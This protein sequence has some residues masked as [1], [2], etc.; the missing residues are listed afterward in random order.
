MIDNPIFGVGVESYGNWYQRYRT[1]DSI[2]ITDDF[3]YYNDN[4]HNYFIQLGANIGLIAF[5]IYSLIY[6]LITLKVLVNMRHFLNNS[7]N[8]SLS[9]V[10]ILFLIPAFVSIDSP[11]ISV[12]FWVIG[13][14]LFGLCTKG[15]VDNIQVNRDK[16]RNL[17]FL[18]IKLFSIFLILSPLLYLTPLLINNVMFTNTLRYGSSLN[19]AQ[20]AEVTR[21]ANNIYALAM[22]SEFIDQRILAIELLNFG[23]ERP[24]LAMNLSERTSIKF[25]LS[26]RNWNL[27]TKIYEEANE[28]QL[29][30]SARKKTI[31]LDPLNRDFRQKLDLLKLKSNF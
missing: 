24:D 8:I 30:F 23:Y 20:K 11:G 12:W 15:K 18:Q 10:W 4:A 28:Y 31:E 27:L 13:G 2:A 1:T 25:P 6:L 26:L 5:F 21:T 9:I 7:S 16:Y 29:A 17:S 22:K 3:Y 14:H 19:F